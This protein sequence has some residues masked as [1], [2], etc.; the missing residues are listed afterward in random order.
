MA[1]ST[2]P[3]V[4]PNG[5]AQLFRQLDGSPWT[6]QAIRET[7]QYASG[8]TE[9]EK[10]VHRHEF[11]HT[12]AARPAM[13]ETPTHVV[14]E[15]NVPRLARGTSRPPDH[16][17]PIEVVGRRKGNRLGRRPG[18]TIVPGG[19]GIRIL[20][21]APTPARPLSSSHRRTLRPANSRALP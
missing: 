21:T 2:H 18:L 12:Q 3:V 10:R 11:R 9:I 15:S 17:G 5:R 1:G 4:L 7:M 8:K 6:P 13:Q 14:R 19:S 16:V 20:L